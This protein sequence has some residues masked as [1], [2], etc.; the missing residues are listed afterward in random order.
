MNTDGTY[1][2]ERYHVV[3]SGRT[4]MAF[5]LQACSDSHVGLSEVPGLASYNMYEVV[6]GG[7]ENSKSVIRR[8]VQG[9]ILAERQ[10]PNIL[11]CDE[12]R[13]FW[14]SWADG[15]IEMGSGAAIGQHRLI[16]Y[17]DPDPYTVNSLTLDTASGFSG[18]YTFGIAS[19]SGEYT[20]DEVIFARF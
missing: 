10:T 8:Q 18:V 17:Q 4:H 2:Y 19:F 12:T 7:W 16:Y 6:I 11:K 9:T 20:V 3:T 1:D 14:I 5:T 13:Y 15:L